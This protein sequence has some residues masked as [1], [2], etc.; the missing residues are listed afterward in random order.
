M[1]V[2]PVRAVETPER[3]VQE[4][5]LAMCASVM[6]LLGICMPCGVGSCSWRSRADSCAQAHMKL[7]P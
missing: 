4:G 5:S 7:A 1:H 2:E 3:S 6:W